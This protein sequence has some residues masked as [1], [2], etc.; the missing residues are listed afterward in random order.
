VQR[1]CEGG[2]VVY[3][4]WGGCVTVGRS[5]LLTRHSWPWVC[6][7]PRPLGSVHAHHSLGCLC[8]GGCVIVFR[9]RHLSWLCGG[10]AHLHPRFSALSCQVSPVPT[11]VLPYYYCQ[12]DGFMLGVHGI[13]RHG[14]EFSSL[15]CV[16]LALKRLFCV[17]CGVLLTSLHSSCHSHWCTR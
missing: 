10:H 5:S 15:R 3:V 8:G 2:I 16:A 7:L 14:R 9:A 17:S 4:W 13:D 11:P 1:C 6:H 12:V